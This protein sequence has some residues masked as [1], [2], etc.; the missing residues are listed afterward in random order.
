MLVVYLFDMSKKIHGILA[1]LHKVGILCII[2]T[3]ACPDA[4]KW[5]RLS[6]CNV[7]CNAT[8]HSANVQ[9]FAPVLLALFTVLCFVPCFSGFA[10]ECGVPLGTAFL[11]PLPTPGLPKSHFLPG[12]LKKRFC[13]FEVFKHA[14]DFFLDF[15]IC[16]NLVF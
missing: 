6:S 10:Q 3:V 7:V 5:V 16:W 11:P 4:I 13:F 2:C 15:R 9:P 12:H 1:F 8:A 14:N